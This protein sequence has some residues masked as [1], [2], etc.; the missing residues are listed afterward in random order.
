MANTATISVA[1]T[2][3]ST[4]TAARIADLVRG[5]ASCGSAPTWS[6]DVEPYL[7]DDEDTLD[8]IADRIAAGDTAGYH[9]SWAII[10]DPE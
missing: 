8:H 4:E 7:R 10:I 5:G 9:P 3:G 2:N 6:L 1:T